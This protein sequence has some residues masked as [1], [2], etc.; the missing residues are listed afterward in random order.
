MK[1]ISIIGEIGSGKTH[2]ANNFG[3]VVFNADKEINKIYKKN[4]KCFKLLKKQFPYNI[5][6]FP[7]SKKEL[8]NLILK[9]KNNILLVGKIVHPFVRKN[10]NTFLKKNK[11]KNKVLDIPLLLEN[12]I[13]IKGNILIFVKSKRFKIIKFLKKRANFNEKLYNIMRKNQFK[14]SY[15]EK[16]ADYIIINNFKK[17]TILK[18]ILSIKNK[19]N[20]SD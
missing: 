11:K 8:T 17:R 16:K 4:R 14:P 13:N 20:K 9:K 10:L 2:V 5:S 18:E 3:Y 7:I 12:K 6:K 19:L 15:K 1:T